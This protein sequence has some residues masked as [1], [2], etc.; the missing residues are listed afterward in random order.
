MKFYIAF[1][2]HGTNKFT[3]ATKDVAVIKDKAPPSMNQMSQVVE[4]I[5]GK[6]FRM[7]TSRRPNYNANADGIKLHW[8][9]LCRKDGKPIQNKGWVTKRFNELK[10]MG[11]TIVPAKP[12]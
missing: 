1:S 11:W 6:D 9:R 3:V 10:K 7:A 4:S 5:F 2:I 12:H 8:S